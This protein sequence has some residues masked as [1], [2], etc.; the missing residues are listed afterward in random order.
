MKNWQR[1]REE[2]TVQHPPG[3]CLKLA[4]KS[5]KIF[6]HC[7]LSQGRDFN[8]DPAKYEAIMMLIRTLRFVWS[9]LFCDCRVTL[10]GRFPWPHGLR[11]GSATARLLGLWV[12]IPPCAWMS[13]CCECYTDDPCK[14]VCLL[15]PPSGSTAPVDQGLL[16]VEVVR[17]HIHTTLDMTPLGE[18]SA[19]RRDLYLTTHNTDN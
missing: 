8:P 17:S 9:G 1:A 18:G 4:R 3:I 5:K 16:I 19:R 15:P 6:Y 10:L 2:A 7:S 12:R 13:V 11:R 14:T